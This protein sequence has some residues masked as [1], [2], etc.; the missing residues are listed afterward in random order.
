MK[1]NQKIEKLEN[2]L[3]E[4]NRE[5]QILKD[6]LKNESNQKQ[7]DLIE[8]ETSY[9][10]A[11]IEDFVFVTGLTYK[12]SYKALTILC[13]N[14]VSNLEDVILL[15]KMNLIDFKKVFSSNINMQDQ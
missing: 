3:L 15:S 11:D 10:S 12:E 13:R 9:A 2:N 7:I 1:L 6:E 14:G 8:R 4:L 5:L